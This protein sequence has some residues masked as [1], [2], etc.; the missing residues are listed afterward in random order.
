MEFSWKPL[1]L[2]RNTKWFEPCCRLPADRGS[3]GVWAYVIDQVLIY[4]SNRY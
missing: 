1:I 4:F 3:I 2:F